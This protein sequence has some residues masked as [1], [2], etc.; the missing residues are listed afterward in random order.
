MMI[1][2]SSLHEEVQL[3]PNDLKEVS[4]KAASECCEATQEEVRSHQP[5]KE[6]VECAIFREEFKDLWQSDAA[7][8]KKH[9]QPGDE[10]QE[11][12]GSASRACGVS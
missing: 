4:R 2:V 9:R 11:P 5:V 12:R 3:R 7:A 6:A 8:Q 1:N 10:V